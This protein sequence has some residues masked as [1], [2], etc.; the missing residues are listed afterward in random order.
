[1]RTL[2]FKKWHSTLKYTEKFSTEEDYAHYT[3]THREKE[4]GQQRRHYKREMTLF[5]SG[6]NLQFPQGLAN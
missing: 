2:F 4:R 1:M 6:K 5:T 3:Q